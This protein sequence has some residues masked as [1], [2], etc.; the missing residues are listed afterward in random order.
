MRMSTAGGTPVL[1]PIVA[2]DLKL[3][4]KPKPARVPAQGEIAPVLAL[5][6]QNWQ[7]K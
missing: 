4:R 6:C 5:S 1:L 3:N 7:L 2:P